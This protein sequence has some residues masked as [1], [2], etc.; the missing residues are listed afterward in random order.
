[1]ETKTRIL[2]AAVELFELH[3]VRGASIRDICSKA[4]ANIAAVNYYFGGKDALYAEVIRSV[5][6]QTFELEPMPDSSQTP[7]TSK[8]QH[9]C[10]W[11][12]WY[13]RRQ[14]NAR[15]M[16]FMNFV[17]LEIADPTAMLQE[18]IDTVINP[19][20]TELRTLVINILPEGSP[21]SLIDF[22]C[23]QVNGPILKRMLLEP[24]N[25]RMPSSSSEIDINATIELTQRSAMAALK[26]SGAI[27]NDQWQCNCC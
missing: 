5:F 25:S 11:I 23:D 2:Q 20:F 27:I 12:D 24:M 1:M 13:I 22:H 7:E 16:K 3:G 6:A 17:R 8:E 18:I 15:T 9:L 19:I 4:E 21:E 14:F 10:N 26:A